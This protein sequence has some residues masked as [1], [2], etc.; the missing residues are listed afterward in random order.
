MTGK[1][2]LL[3]QRDVAGAAWVPYRSRRWYHP[4]AAS[5]TD[6]LISAPC[7][8]R[9]CI[10]F[11]CGSP[12]WQL[13]YSTVAVDLSVTQSLSVIHIGWN[14]LSCCNLLQL[15]LITLTA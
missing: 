8:C 11:T 12:P 3:E 15:L 6:Q 4:V 7:D 2:M 10:N 14:Y 9:P 1:V 5:L 13:R